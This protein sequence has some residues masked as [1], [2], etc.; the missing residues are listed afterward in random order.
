MN[1]IQAIGGET[2]YNVVIG[3]KSKFHVSDITSKWRAHKRYGGR[4][5]TI[6]TINEI[7]QLPIYIEDQLLLNSVL[8]QIWDAPSNV[9]FHSIAKSIELDNPIKVAKKTLFWQWKELIESLLLGYLSQSKKINIQTEMTRW[10]SYVAENKIDTSST[11]LYCLFNDNSP[12]NNK[13][14]DT[15]IDFKYLGYCP[16]AQDAR[17]K[18]LLEFPI[19]Q[20]CPTKLEGKIQNIYS[21]I[22]DIPDHDVVVDIDKSPFIDNL[23]EFLERW[24]EFNKKIQPHLEKLE[25]SYILAAKRIDATNKQI[26]ALITLV[27]KNIKDLYDSDNL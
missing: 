12:W 24:I 17:I 8:K 13:Y 23:D 10:Q 19:D 1:T 15:K 5:Y 4:N 26:G 20:F 11:L 22:R 9:I 2:I 14:F 25:A 27:K 7:L 3:G 6:K 21:S 18:A 16:H